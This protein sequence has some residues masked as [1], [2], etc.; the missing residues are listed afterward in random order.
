MRRHEWSVRVRVFHAPDAYGTFVTA[1]KIM[2]SVEYARWLG[3]RYFASHQ[4]SPEGIRAG[5][6]A[7]TGTGSG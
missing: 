6:T 1:Q 5:L 3:R 7:Q 4:Y 2:P